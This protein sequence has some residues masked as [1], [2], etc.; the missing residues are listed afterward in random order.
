MIN[1]IR[2]KNILNNDKL[3]IISNEIKS[4]NLHINK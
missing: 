4:S 1:I 3:K 2:N